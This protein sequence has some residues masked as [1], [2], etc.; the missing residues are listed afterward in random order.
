MKRLPQFVI[1]SLRCST[2]AMERRT[3]REARRP[4]F[5]GRGGRHPMLETASRQIFRQ[6]LLHVMKYNRIPEA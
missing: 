6:L 1:F 3:E 2:G 5:D 4:R